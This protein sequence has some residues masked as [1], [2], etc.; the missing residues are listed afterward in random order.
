MSMGKAMS[1][2]L[3]LGIVVF[4]LA[5]LIPEKITLLTPVNKLKKTPVQENAYYDYL[6]AS[7]NYIDLP[8]LEEKELAP[9]ISLC[10]NLQRWDSEFITEV[11]EKN[12]LSLSLWDKAAEKQLCIFPVVLSDVQLLKH[13]ANARDIAHLNV[14]NIYNLISKQKYDD[15]TALIKKLLINASH[16]TDNAECMVTLLVGQ[17]LKSSTYQYIRTI[18]TLDILDTAELQKLRDLMLVHKMNPRSC[19]KAIKADVYVTKKYLYDFERGQRTLTEL[20]QYYDKFHD[21]DVARINSGAGFL[22]AKKSMRACDEYLAKLLQNERKYIIDQDPNLDDRI[23]PKAKN[24]FIDIFNNG[25]GKIMVEALTT[26]GSI[27]KI[28]ALMKINYSLN[29][30]YIA[31][32]IYKKE[33]GEYPEKLADLC[34]SILKKVPIDAYDGKDIRYE[35]GVRIYTAYPGETSRLTEISLVED[36]DCTK[37]LNVQIKK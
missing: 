37:L 33:H 21:S 28:N 19:P 29:L 13:L 36:N 7:K 31:C 23:Y 30:T 11:L 2:M 22:D 24:K 10:E 26:L 25:I 4:L 5:K 32:E 3:T 15:I 16:Y 9:Y 35:K 12:K 8:E 17:G 1:I 27:P 14:L 20:D 18:L 6:K 34:P